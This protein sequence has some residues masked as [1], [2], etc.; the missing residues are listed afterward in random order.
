MARLAEEIADRFGP[1]PE[2]V[3]TLL[4]AAGM[5]ALG[6]VLGVETLSLSPEGVSLC[7]REGVSMDDRAPLAC[8]LEGLAVEDRRL[9][10]HHPGPED[11]LD[12]AADLLE[13]LA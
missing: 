3:E 11:R 1:P 10:L 7:F 13:R 9:T 2:P 12:L 5:R 6:A 8:G 4:R